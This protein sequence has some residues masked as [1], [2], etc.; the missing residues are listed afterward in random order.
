MTSL[1]FSLPADLHNLTVEQTVVLSAI[2]SLYC[3]ITAHKVHYTVGLH[4]CRLST[5]LSFSTNTMHTLSTVLSFL[6]EWSIN[7]NWI[8]LLLTLIIFITSTFTYYC[9]YY[10]A[11]TNRLLQPLLL[12][13]NCY[14]IIL[15]CLDCIVRIQRWYFWF[16]SSSSP[17]F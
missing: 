15:C 13:Q 1:V 7:L 2:R 14:Y 16:P 6:F 8:P 3:Y 5:D 17:K 11:F 4:N 9:Y 12:T 10:A